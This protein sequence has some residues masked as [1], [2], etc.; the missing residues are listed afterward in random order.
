MRGYLPRILERDVE[1][2]LADAPS[3]ALLEPRKRGKA[4]LIRLAAHIDAGG[5]HPILAGWG[6]C[7]SV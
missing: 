1:R 5:M 6:Q 7:C 2:K 3:V 4:K